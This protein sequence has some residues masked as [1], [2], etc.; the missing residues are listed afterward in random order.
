MYQFIKEGRL[1]NIQFVSV[2]WLTNT[3]G[4]ELGYNWKSAI[5]LG[6]GILNLFGSHVFDYLS[7]FLGKLPPC[8]C[9]TASLVP[10]RMGKG[11]AKKVT[12]PDT[13]TLLSLSGVPLSIKLSSSLSFNA[14]HSVK[15]WG[16][17]GLLEMEHESIE[18]PNGF[19][20]R[21]TGLN[22]QVNVLS[23]CSD[24]R[25]DIAGRAL[26]LFQRAVR[27]E[28]VEYPSLKEGMRVQKILDEMHG[29]L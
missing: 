15:L 14:G 16:S 11:R 8:I 21:F 27:E 26:S 3:R 6:G 1:G 10:K 25:I 7:W 20:A 12:A 4:A 17:N 13:C 23:E 18:F 29:Y 24:S 2:S 22:N 5:H 28:E 19:C 9:T